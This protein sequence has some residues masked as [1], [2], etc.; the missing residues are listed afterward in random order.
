MFVVEQSQSLLYCFRIC[1]L[2]NEVLNF[3]RVDMMSPIAEEVEVVE[4]EP[5][6]VV[7]ARHW[8]GE[9][10]GSRRSL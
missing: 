8:T 5:D 9:L 7:L 2:V 4:R 1:A 6:G 10:I 3:L